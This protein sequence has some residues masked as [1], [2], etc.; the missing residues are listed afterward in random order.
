MLAEFHQEAQPLGSEKP[1][2]SPA[3]SLFILFVLQA[4]FATQH[5]FKKTIEINWF[6]TFSFANF[7]L[8][9]LP[10]RSRAATVSYVES[11]STR[12]L[13]LKSFFLRL[14]PRNVLLEAL[15]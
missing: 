2:N 12:D 9:R 7:H 13:P 14:S 5:L 4:D 1:E 10:K 3:T 15:F 6:F 8:I 11:F